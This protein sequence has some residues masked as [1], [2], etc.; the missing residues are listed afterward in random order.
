M[1]ATNPQTELDAATLTDLRELVRSVLAEDVGDGDRTAALVPDGQQARARVIAR[2]AAVICGQPWFDEVFRLLDESICVQWH[3]ADGHQV[4]AN[5]LVCDITGPARAILTGERSALNL[6]QTLSATATAT[7]SYVDAVTGTSARI[8]D[9]RKTLP[10]LRRAQKYAVRCGGG[11]NHRLGL[12]DAILIKENHIV[13]AGSIRAA[14]DAARNAG[15]MVEIEVENLDELREALATSAD[16]LLLDNF[17]LDDLATAVSIRNQ[18]APGI[19]L[20]ASGGITL[21]NVQGIAGTGVDFISIGALTKD[22]AAVDLSMRF[23][24]N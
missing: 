23:Q 20:E 13:A 6:L 8:L 21:G 1:S 7:R 18:Q 2:Q 22:I 19:L 14:A 12:Y 11:L 17:S 9:T 10:R 3:V 5:A 24:F 15:V 4:V 16:R